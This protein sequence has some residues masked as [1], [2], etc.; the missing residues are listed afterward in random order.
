[1]KFILNN[2]E[3]LLSGIGLLVIWL[4]P[5]LVVRGQYDIW[6]ATA[7]TAIAVGLIHGFIFWLIRRRQRI[8][9]QEAIREI[10]L[11]LSDMI[12]NELTI[13]MA[14]SSDPRN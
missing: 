5:S 13:I 8:V 1:M 2:I 3:L 9:R 4:V 7:V 6:K 11:M 10:R 12:N 14:G